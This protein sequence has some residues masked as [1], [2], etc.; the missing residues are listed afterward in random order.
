MRRGI[1]MQEKYKNAFLVLLS[2]Q[3]GNLQK[4]CPL[5]ETSL[6]WKIKATYSLFRYMVCDCPV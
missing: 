1:A 2:G 4:A 6:D 3:W 5:E